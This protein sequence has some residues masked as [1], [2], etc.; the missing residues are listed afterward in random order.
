MK[1]IIRYSLIFAIISLTMGCEKEL[2]TYPFSIRVINEEGIPLPNITVTATA[3]VPNALPDFTGITNEEGLVS[4]EYQF[5]AVLKIRATRGSSPP[6]WMGCN[7]IK[8]EADKKVQVDV[9]VLKYDPSQ[10]GC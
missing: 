7:F 5:E 6:S 3:D 4:F 2:P 10:P 9:V 8:L 1:N